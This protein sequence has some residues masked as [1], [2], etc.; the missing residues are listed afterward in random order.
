AVEACADPTWASL[1]LGR[2]P[3][4]LV[5][6]YYAAA[7]VLLLTAHARSYRLAL[8]SPAA[9]ARAAYDRLPAGSAIAAALLTALVAWAGAFSLPE[10][11]PRLTFFEDSGATLLQTAAGR[12]V[13][14]EPGPSGRAIS[15]DLGRTL[16]FWSATIDLLI[17]PRGEAESVPEL[18]RRYRIAQI[19]APEPPDASIDLDAP[20][21]VG[22]AIDS[23]AGR[24]AGPAPGAARWRDAAAAAGVPVASPPDGTS[25]PL[26]EGAALDLLQPARPDAP[27]AMR[28]VVGPH[29]VLILGQAS[30]AA[31]RALVDLV[32]DPVDVIHLPADSASLDPTLRDRL[33]PR[34][35]I[36]D[37]R[38]NMPPRTPPRPDERLAVLR[39]DDHGTVVL[40]LR[41][42]SL[43]LRSRR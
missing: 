40:T 39:S 9:L 3:T 4:A 2:L 27:Y 33:A 8:P 21:S 1:P 11:A 17:L 10:G 35:A 25:I 7:A 20:P 6:S 13:L 37:V 23:G 32:S 15:A 34:V 14:I 26:G 29:R 38:P 16:P 5:W 19:V 41:P 22:G 28:L 24:A 42:S 36:L 43:E 30:T 31:Q 18:L 12:G